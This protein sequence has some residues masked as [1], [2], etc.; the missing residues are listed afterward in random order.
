[1]HRTQIELL[2]NEARRDR[3]ASI[4]TGLSSRRARRKEDL[5]DQPIEGDVFSLAKQA[6]ADSESYLTHIAQ[7]M[8][9]AADQLR[10]GQDRDGLSTFA[11]GASDLYEFLQLLE[12]LILAAKPSSQ[13]ETDAFRKQLHQAVGTLDGVLRA[14]DLG[15]LSDRIEDCLLPIVP[16]WPA[17]TAELSVGLAAQA[18]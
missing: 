7:L 12:Q 1:M 15:S 9:S 5:M 10:A 18:I 3:T 11:R 4:P 6:L 16:R 17:V 2:I 14:Q 13:G 8:S